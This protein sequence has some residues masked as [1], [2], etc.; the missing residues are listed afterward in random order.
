MLPPS[1]PLP[2]PSLSFPSP[3]HS[4]P[5]IPPQSLS[6]QSTG[7]QRFFTLAVLSIQNTPSK[8]GPRRKV[9]LDLY[10]WYV[11]KHVFMLSKIK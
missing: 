5:P 3:P 4:S 10:S 8:P 1:P 6:T 9:L 11:V 7:S 2:I